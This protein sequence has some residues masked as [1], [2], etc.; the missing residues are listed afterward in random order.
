MVLENGQHTP[1]YHNNVNDRLSLTIQLGDEN[2]L[3]FGLIG[4][5]STLLILF[6]RFLRR[7]HSYF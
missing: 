5:F 2:I 7:R 6:C 1:F 4:H 3:M